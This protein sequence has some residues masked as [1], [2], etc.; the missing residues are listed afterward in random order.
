MDIGGI[1][2]YLK[3]NMR[4]HFLSGL[5]DSNSVDMY[6]FEL[7]RWFKNETE[8]T[9]KRMDCEER[10]YIKEQVASGAEHINDSG[11]FATDYYRSRMRSSHV[12]FLA[13]LLEGAM[14][15]ECDRLKQALGAQVLFQPSDLSGDPWKKRKTFLQ[16]YGRLAIP[17]SVWKPVKEILDVRNALVH[18][19]G[20]V[21]L[22]T[23]QQIANLGKIPGIG[24]DS[25]EIS[26]NEEYLE[27]AIDSVREV[28]EFLH[29][30]INDVIDLAL[31]PRGI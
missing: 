27:R 17:D 19:S 22:M 14:K 24:V 13:S 30:K 12:I 25:S 26:I 11:L 7:F 6:E 29:M 9:W 8:E 15:R 28:V 4:E 2:E 10:Q 23:D 31:R 3:T 1:P 20:Q 5:K 16:R 18:H 21:A